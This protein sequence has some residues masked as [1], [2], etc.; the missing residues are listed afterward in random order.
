MVDSEISNMKLDTARRMGMDPKDL[1]ED[2]FP[3][4][5][6]EEEALKRVKIGMLLNVIIEDNEF[7]ADPDKVKQ[8]IEDRA[9]NYKEPQQVINYF[10]SDEEQ[11]K[12]IESI[13]LE[14]QVVDLLISSAKCTDEELTYEECISGN[15]QG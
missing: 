4:E 7:K 10:Y 3:N 5:T 14:E 2:L 1:K 11:L 13:S 9:K 15:Y 8:I 12:N 6:F